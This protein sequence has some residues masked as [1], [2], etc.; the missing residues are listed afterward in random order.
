MI[1]GSLDIKN[2]WLSMRRKNTAGLFLD[3]RVPQFLAKTI[4]PLK[5]FHQS[6][7]APAPYPTMHHSEQKYAYFRS[8]WC[9]VGC[10]THRISEDGTWNKKYLVAYHPFSKIHRKIPKAWDRW[11]PAISNAEPLAKILAISLIRVF[12]SAVGGENV[13]EK[14]L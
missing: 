13:F 3:T 6:H 5:Q 4:R 8:E 9:L 14:C 7:R 1:P 2:D 12:V 11:L 10:G